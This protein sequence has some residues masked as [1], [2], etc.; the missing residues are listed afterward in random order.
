MTTATRRTGFTDAA[1]VRLLAS[2]GVQPADGPP[3]DFHDQLSG[4]LRWTDAQPLFAALQEPLTVAPLSDDEDA[5]ADSA[6]ADS[7]AV[8]ALLTRTLTEDAPWRE[9]AAPRRRSATS[10]WIATSAPAPTE[11]AFDFPTYR[12]HVVAQQQSMED[13]IAPL[14]ARLRRALELRSPAHAR[15]AALDAVME[16]MLGAPESRLLDALPGLLDKRFAQLRAAA[17]D[18][19]PTTSSW[20]AGFQH[21]LEAA[22]HAELDLRWHPIRAL[23]AALHTP[24]HANAVA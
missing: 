5:S 11:M 12:R 8:H 23:L 7:Q 17:A 18:D 19:A 6:E 13:R 16:R 1:L 15:M 3:S 21:D 24:D 14:R 2:W 20:Q 4:W 9:A 10:G 22:L